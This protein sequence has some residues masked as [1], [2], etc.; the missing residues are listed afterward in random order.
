M[1][2]DN[3][4]IVTVETAKAVETAKGPNETEND[5]IAF[6]T[7][8]VVP[9]VATNNTGVE[10]HLVVGKYV[11]GKA[12]DVMMSEQEEEIAKAQE[13]STIAIPATIN[14][15]DTSLKPVASITTTNESAVGEVELTANFPQK[16]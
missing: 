4:V 6:S 16:V 1:K 5:G 11:E 2:D 9:A 15:G 13:T 7:A 3:C 10:N 14:E 12:V 8:T